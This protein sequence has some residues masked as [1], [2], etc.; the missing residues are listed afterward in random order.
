MEMTV[1]TVIYPTPDEE[2]SKNHEIKTH[3]YL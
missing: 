2:R 1:L 3:R